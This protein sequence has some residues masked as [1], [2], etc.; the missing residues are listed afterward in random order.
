VG[1]LPNLVDIYPPFDRPLS[2]IYAAA[3]QKTQN[4]S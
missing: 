2:E 4:K 1:K 3:Q